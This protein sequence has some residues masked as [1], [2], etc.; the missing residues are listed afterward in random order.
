MVVVE[1]VDVRWRIHDLDDKC[2]CIGSSIGQFQLN[3]LLGHLLKL[4]QKLWEV[5]DP[6]NRQES[7]SSFPP[8]LPLTLPSLILRQSFTS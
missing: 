1:R 3:S 7:S 6:Q 4:L 8:F 2:Q 5:A